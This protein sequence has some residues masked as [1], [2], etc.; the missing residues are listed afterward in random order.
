MADKE[1]HDYDEK[2]GLRALTG[3]ELLFAEEQM[4]ASEGMREGEKLHFAGMIRRGRIPRK[5]KAKPMRRI[6]VVGKYSLLFIKRSRLG[7][8]KV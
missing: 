2:I 6:I 5:K 1:A 4:R 7:R 8:Q 3:E